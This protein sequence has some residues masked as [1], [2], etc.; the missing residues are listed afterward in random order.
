[1]SL[2]CFTKK[3]YLF[4]IKML[5]QLELSQAWWILFEDFHEILQQSWKHLLGAFANPE[6]APLSQKKHQLP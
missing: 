6:S 2:F 1:M 4:Q 3:D 5:V